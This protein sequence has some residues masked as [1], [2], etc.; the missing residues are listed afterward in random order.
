ML[1]CKEILSSFYGNHL[2]KLMERYTCILLVSLAIQT[3][4]CKKGKGL[5]NC[6]YKLCP[7]ALYSAVQS[8][9]SILSHDALHHCLSSNSSLENGKRELASS[10]GSL[11]KN[12]G[13][14]GGEGGES[15]VTSAGKVVDFR[16][17]ALAVPIRLQNETTCT[18]DILSTQQKIINL[19]MNL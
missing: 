1:M 6:V 15:L 2:T 5:V 3:H 18:R 4:L 17:L 11:L 19:K 8:R 13:G 14:G 10:P 9:C 7:T 16:R 12:G